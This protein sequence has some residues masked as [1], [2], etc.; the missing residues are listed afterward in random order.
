METIGNR[1]PTI[2]ITH[3]NDDNF[4]LVMDCYLVKEFDQN[5]YDTK[6]HQHSMC[7]VFEITKDCHSYDCLARVVLK[8]NVETDE[9]TAQYVG[10][11]DNGESK[12]LTDIWNAGNIG[13]GVCFHNVIKLI[14]QLA[15]IYCGSDSDPCDYFKYIDALKLTYIKDAVHFIESDGL[16][17]SEVN[18]G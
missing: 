9:W 18:N 4:D 16:T 2:R 10:T 7:L 3:A 5:T 11:T 8:Y 6:S 14:R 17:T 12:E 1:L 15:A 13:D